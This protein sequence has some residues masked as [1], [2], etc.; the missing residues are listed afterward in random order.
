[1]LCGELEVS[2]DDLAQVFREQ[3]LSASPCQESLDIARGLADTDAIEPEIR[4]L[5]YARILAD[6]LRG[7]D[8]SLDALAERDPHETL[9]S[10]PPPPAASA[11][12]TERTLYLDCAADRTLRSTLRSDGRTSTWCERSDG[13]PDGPMVDWSWS[14]VPLRVAD[15]RDDVV[16]DVR[17]PRVG[18]PPDQGGIAWL[19]EFLFVCAHHLTHRETKEHGVREHWCEDERGRRQGSSMRWGPSGLVLKAGRYEDGEARF[20]A[21]VNVDASPQVTEPLDQLWQRANGATDPATLDALVGEVEQLLAQHPDHPEVLMLLARIHL[22]R[23]DVEAAFGPASR[24]TEVLPTMAD[25]WLTTAVMQ[26]IRGE[27][28][29]AFR[30]YQTYLQHDPAGRFAMRAHHAL[31]RLGE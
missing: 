17:F 11:S 26:E 16:V 15:V 24:C 4:P 9:R 30:R 7:A 25:C 29:D 1:M 10:L 14:G 31:E 3:S 8:V 18:R 21:Y 22:G 6:T 5:I 2:C 27:P 20:M 28:R 13:V 23:E 19:P 12:E